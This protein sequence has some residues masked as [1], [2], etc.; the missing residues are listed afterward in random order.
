MDFENFF[1]QRA[2]AIEFPT[3][4][5]I[6]AATA[7]YQIEGA[8]SED[9]RGESIWDR[10][11][12]E[13]GL[14]DS[15]DTA[16][17]AC[18]HYSRFKS[19]VEIMASLSVNAYR[20]SISWPRIFPDGRGSINM[21]GVDFYRRL[22][23]ELLDNGIKPFATLYHWDLPQSLQEQGGGWLRRG[24]SDDFAAFADAVTRRVSEVEHWTTINEPWTFC[25]WG[26]GFGSEAPGISGGAKS[27]LAAI[28]HALLAHGKAVPAIRAN[29][30]SAE[31]GIVLDIN[32]VEAATSEP[33]DIAAAKRFDGCQNRW[34]LDAL[35]NSGYPPDMLELF[36]SD[37]PAV[38]DGDAAAISAPV[39]FLGINFYRRSVI[40][41]GDDFLPLNIRRA[42]P[43]GRATAMG[44]EVWPPSICDLLIQVN[45][46]YRPKAIY[47]TENG[48]AF[49]DIAVSGGKIN[50][51]NRTDYIVSHLEQCAK[52][53]EEGVS[54]K[55][56]FAW[57]LLDNFEWTYGYGKR[58]GLVRVDFENGL[59]RTVK[60]S[61]EIFRIIAMRVGGR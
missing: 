6:G 13:S 4:F 25:W 17:V 55:G 30:P 29:N 26:Y 60:R 20:F 16:R 3:G 18:D 46:D 12:A 49:D 14:I 48:A 34:F 33:K 19:D 21:K 56:Y 36:G 31:V 45:R 15:G 58:F 38:L 57:S 5:L 35:F 10:F 9:G 11:V 51:L 43:E 53:I 23:D 37:A 22:V 8:I 32:G 44:W 52:A 7:A 59:I 39:D 61:G 47:I 42:A 2:N 27:A 1:E 41:K 28:H 54:L 40:G 50:D 24:I